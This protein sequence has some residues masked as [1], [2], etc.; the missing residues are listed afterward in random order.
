MNCLPDHISRNPLFDMTTVV[1]YINDTF[2]EVKQHIVTFLMLSPKADISPLPRELNLQQSCLKGEWS[3]PPPPITSENKQ[4][5]V[6]EN[7]N[8][9]ITQP[10]K[11][12]SLVFFHQ[13]SIQTGEAPILMF[14]TNELYMHTFIHITVW[15]PNTVTK[16]F[17]CFSKKKTKYSATR[18]LYLKVDFIPISFISL[19]I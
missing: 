7:A 17:S 4:T 13:I 16:G 18:R 14:S 5:L 6:C 8:S 11:C 15:C 1:L 3:F 9:C 19:L 12:Y 10:S 2:V